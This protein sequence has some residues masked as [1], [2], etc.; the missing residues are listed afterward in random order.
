MDE[1]IKVYIDSRT[2]KKV[3]SNQIGEKVLC[4]KQVSVASGDHLTITFLNG[5][6][7]HNFQCFDTNDDLFSDY[8]HVYKNDTFEIS[9][10]STF[11]GVVNLL[12]YSKDFCKD[13][14]LQIVLNGT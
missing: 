13:S 4:G 11:D 8:T 9:F 3:Y 2:G 14:N 10:S 12:Y 5:C 6:I 1:K 7:L